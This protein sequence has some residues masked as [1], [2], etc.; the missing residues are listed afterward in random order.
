MGFWECIRLCKAS[1]CPSLPQESAND[2]SLSTVSRSFA[3]SVAPPLLLTHSLQLLDSSH[4][5]IT[6]D[7]RLPRNRISWHLGSSFC[8]L[9]KQ[10]NAFI[11]DDLWD[12]PPTHTHTR[13]PP[14]I[15]T[16]LQFNTSELAANPQMSTMAFHPSLAWQSPL[17]PTTTPLPS[18]S[19][20]SLVPSQRNQSIIRQGTWPTPSS[21]CQLGQSQQLPG[22]NMERCV[23]LTT[24]SLYTAMAWTVNRPRSVNGCG[25]IV[26]RL[27][28]LIKTHSLCL[29]WSS[30]ILNQT[31]WFY[32]L[33]AFRHARP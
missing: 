18:A 17:P 23:T 31:H 12:T 2:V 22:L 8:P 1:L 5:T 29:V 15:I 33:C 4:V 20:V 13:H 9:Y 27:P 24:L 28:L 7:S 14:P 16:C 26:Y 10:G 32:S 6:Q 30:L 3:L 25:T 19:Q 11:F 21:S